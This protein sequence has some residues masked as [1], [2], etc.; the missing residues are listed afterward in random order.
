MTVKK[1]IE[2]MRERYSDPLN[3]SQQKDLIVT[4]CDV[5]ERQME[6][7]EHAIALE[8]LWVPTETDAEHV[9]EATALSSLHFE[10]KHT[11]AETD[12]LCEDVK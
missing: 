4:L 11:L 3:C 7:L 10:I 5:I 12:K 9:D 6:T 1:M 2:K 8:D